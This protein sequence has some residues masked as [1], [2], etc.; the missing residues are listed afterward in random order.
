MRYWIFGVLVWF[1]IDRFSTILHN[2]FI[3]TVAI[4]A[5][6]SPNNADE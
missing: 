1:V 6:A 5:P 3:D 4:V 2:N